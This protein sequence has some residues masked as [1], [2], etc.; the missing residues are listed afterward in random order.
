MEIEMQFKCLLNWNGSRLKDM[1]LTVKIQ[2]FVEL[3]YNKNLLYF[4]S[5]DLLMIISTQVVLRNIVQ[6]PRDL[7]HR[8][9][10]LLL[11]LCII[12]ISYL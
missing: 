3:H 10:I 5:I 4:P 11:A 6:N 12:I 7:I 8:L 2:H 1:R 9:L